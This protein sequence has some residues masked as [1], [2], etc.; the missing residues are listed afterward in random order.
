[1]IGEGVSLI[2]TQ[3]SE[4]SSVITNNGMDYLISKL[5][6]RIKSVL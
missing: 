5:N 4:F 3:R 2:A 1:I 6:D